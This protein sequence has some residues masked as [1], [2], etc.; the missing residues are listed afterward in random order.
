M[1]QIQPIAIEDG[2]PGGGIAPL[3]VQVPSSAHARR[4][5]ALPLWL[6]LLLSN[7]K[8]RGGLIV[9]AGML[10][11]AIFAPLLATHDP[12]AYSLLDAKQ[13]PSWNHLFGTTDQGTDIWSQVVWGTRNS[14]FLGV[15]AAT[16]ATVL[17]AGLGILAA[18]SGGWIDDVINFA[19]N[20]F[21][22]IPTIPL[23]IVASAYLKSRGSLSMILILGLTLWA[24]EARILRAQALTLRN[25]D[26]ILAAKVAGEPTWRIVV[27]ELMPNMISRIAAAF[28]LVFYIS[29]LTAAG[30]QFLGLGDMNSQSWGVTLY[31]A[32][33]NSAVLQGEWWPFLFPGLALAVTVLGLVFVLAGLDE[34]SNP[35][36]RRPPRGRGRLT[37]LLFGGRGR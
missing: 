3:E 1:S 29:L 10:A 16:L 35:R 9:L 20:V 31:W 37:S 7:P 15:A 13:S 12:T 25:R 5:F 2:T 30:L 4:R 21:L 14:L 22:V 23:L 11:V 27:F 34:V 24:F 32:Q 8:S 36:L 19:T 18:Y 26:F 28:V 6:R 33:V 17:A